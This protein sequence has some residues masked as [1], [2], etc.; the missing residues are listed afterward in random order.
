MLN[1]WLQ[2]VPHSLR[3]FQVL[4]ARWVPSP[5]R[6]LPR[7]KQRFAMWLREPRV[8]E[9]YLDL[10]GNSLLNETLRLSSSRPSVKRSWRRAV[11][12]A[13]AC[14]KVRYHGRWI[15]LKHISSVDIEQARRRQAGSGSVVVHAPR[16]P[17]AIPDRHQLRY[18]SVNVGGLPEHKYD[19]LL[20]YCQDNSVDV[21]A[22]Q[23][24]R[25]KHSMCWTSGSYR[26]IQSGEG[27]SVGKNSYAGVLVAISGKHLLS[28][29]EV[30]AGRLLLIRLSP[31][32]SSSTASSQQPP[33][34][35]VVFYNKVLSSQG[36][37]GD[38]A[39]ASLEVRS[40]LWTKLDTLLRSLPR[41]QG[42]LILGDLNCHVDKHSPYVASGDPSGATSIDE[43]D[44]I[45]LLERH[46][47][48]V[49][50]TGCKNKAVTFRKTLEDNPSSGT[51]PDYVILR[52][53][54]RR[55]ASRVTTHWHLPFSTP[56]IAGWHATLRG[57]LDLRWTCWRKGSP[58]AVQQR[59]HQPSIREAL[60]PEHPRQDAFLENLES[61]LSGL[62]WANADCA[63][64]LL[65]LND[66]VLKSGLEIFGAPSS[67]RRPPPWATPSSMRLSM[68]KW[69][70]FKALRALRSP[71]SL[72]DFF[73]CWK[74]ASKSMLQDRLYKQHCR[75][76]RQDWVR[77]ICEQASEAAKRR[78]HDFFRYVHMLAPKRRREAPGITRKLRGTCNM[79]EE[80]DRFLTHFKELFQS[81]APS[82]VQIP[83][84]WNWLPTSPTCED[85]EPYLSKMPL[86]KA[87]PVGHPL[88]SIWRLAFRSSSV[89]SWVNHILSEIPKSGVPSQFRNGSLRLLFK[90]GKKGDEVS[91]YRPLVL[92]CPLGKSILKWIGHRVFLHVRHL[93][94]RHPQFAYLP[95]RSAEMAIHRVSSFL[96]WRKS[97][98]GYAII[99]AE[100]RK[101]GWKQPDCSGCLLVSLDLTNAFDLVDREQLF[102][103]LSS[104][105]IPQDLVNVIRG[106]HFHSEYSLELGDKCY[107]IVTGRG[108]RQGCTLAPLLWLIY[109]YSTIEELRASVPYVDW[110]SLIT[111]YAD[112]LILCIPI[113]SALGMEEALVITQLFLQ[114]LSKKGLKINMLKTQFFLKLVG[115][116]AQ[117][118]FR[119]H[120]T[121]C[122]GKLSL[123]LGESVVPLAKTIDYLGVQLGWANSAD[124]TLG[125][126]LKKG[127][128]AFAS[129]RAWWKRSALHPR[130]QVDLY[131]ST[132][133]PVITYGL[134]S[135]G[136]TRKGRSRL[137]T[138]IFKQLRRI[139]RL[140]SH[141]THV[142]NATIIQRYDIIHPVL[143]VQL[144]CCRLW[145]QMLSTLSEQVCEA[146]HLS[147]YLDIHAKNTTPW[148]ESVVAGLRYDHQACTSPL[149]AEIIGNQ[150]ASKSAD[151]FR[152]VHHRGILP[153]A[154]ERM[155]KPSMHHFAS[156]VPSEYV[157]AE[158][159]RRFPT[160]NQLRSHQF[161]S[162]CLW[163][164]EEYTFVPQH[165]CGQ[166]LP[167]CRWC[168]RNF[169][170]WGALQTHISRGH[171]EALH[172]RPSP[173][174]PDPNKPRLY[175][176]DLDLSRFCVICARWFPLS[177]SL[178]KHLK[179]AH[180]LDYA[181]ATVEYKK[182]NFSGFKFK[183]AC[184]YCSTPQGS[185]NL[186]PHIKHHCV[187]L[188]QRFIAQCPDPLLQKTLGSEQVSPVHHGEESRGIDCSQLV[189][190][191]RKRTI[192]SLGSSTGTKA[193]TST[194]SRA[195]RLN[196][197]ILS[198]NSTYNFRCKHG[199]RGEEG[200]GQEQEQRQGEEQGTRQRS[201]SWPQRGRRQQF[202]SG[203]LSASSCQAS[204]LTSG[205]T[206]MYVTIDRSH[207]PLRSLSGE[208]H[209]TKHDGMLESMENDLCREPREDKRTPSG[210]ALEVHS[211]LPVH[212]RFRARKGDRA[213]HPRQVP[214]QGR[215]L[216]DHLGGE[217]GEGHPEAC[218]PHN[219][220]RGTECDS[221][222]DEHPLPL[223]CHREAQDSQANGSPVSRSHSTCSVEHEFHDSSRDAIVR[224]D[225]STHGTLPMAF[226]RCS[227][228]GGKG[229]TYATSRDCEIISVST[230]WVSSSLP[231][232]NVQ[233]SSSSSS[234]E[235]LLP[236]VNDG[237]LCYIN[238]TVNMICWAC[239]ACP[240]FLSSLPPTWRHALAPLLENA[241]SDRSGHRPVHIPSLPTWRPLLTGWRLGAQEDVS[242]FLL[243]VLEQSPVSAFAGT[244][245]LINAA[246]QHPET[247]PFVLLNVPVPKE[248][249]Q[250]DSSS[251]YSLS[252]IMDLWSRSGDSSRDRDCM[253]LHPPMLLL[254][255]LLRYSFEGHAQKCFSK[256]SVPEHVAIPS[257]IAGEI[258]STSYRCIA[259]ILHHGVDPTCGHYT[260]VAHSSAGHWHLDD[261]RLPQALT[262][263]AAEALASSDMYILCLER[264]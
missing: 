81:P 218:R 205:T 201:F 232:R 4:T 243:H 229:E 240:A 135:V 121:Y 112:D 157:C 198:S 225:A 237:T 169:K 193:K 26:V 119:S 207:L 18:L 94:L 136:L 77:H 199:G 153:T 150:I 106:W 109:L 120:T 33:L 197:S 8:A 57:S 22:V 84:E 59:F 221:G 154:Y 178:S 173:P 151:W 210:G 227:D 204:T 87:V 137:E 155:P 215:L 186:L 34:N 17:H 51:R 15:R 233:V 108:V 28:Y 222:R 64:P 139:L 226:D 172:L 71:R 105:D 189:H 255:Q 100:W 202:D 194:I 88:G 114:F 206:P 177:R 239:L 168:G 176:L 43:A 196:C 60:R 21:V 149:T 192:F 148:W 245:V 118:I 31:P 35:I 140:P 92:Q 98:A 19:A 126:R 50:N 211:C 20:Q 190:P 69:R 200:H 167:I 49:H 175:H 74:V 236:L 54:M 6:S 220:P 36:Y 79:S 191:S 40:Q 97:Q 256:I 208:R 29:E 32:S 127:R 179:S 235:S 39:A 1:T 143:R 228:E 164:K 96:S 217:D 14:G 38:V 223:G 65:T 37:D 89:K 91:H 70:C 257:M 46:D 158:C 73:L 83:N 247:Q 86:F 195:H 53:S 209:C 58:A 113:D 160:Y 124:L 244:M 129:L 68:L 45:S 10:C 261:S 123:K 24:T 141:L 47:L 216:R 259:T 102:T 144:A 116:K 75:Q 85:L 30:V 234:A 170:W 241:N 25:R 80:H 42:I 253:L 184:P 145:R 254:V 99:P 132:V 161:G 146:G 67:K 27:D 44:M 224:A 134:G 263:S 48:R 13:L 252:T 163:Q 12:R 122:E 110:L 165:D 214:H 203:H 63:D 238:S 183:H 188:L 111:A 264:V 9:L 142:S 212:A 41:R 166:A 76:L 181:R 219:E 187:V 52:S 11:Q 55:Q 242:E 115:K 7:F 5:N 231:D 258:V 125:L 72:A 213:D 156:S 2:P 82:Q 185:N 152:E 159:D 251:T 104:L 90:P 249:A 61:K 138:E 246:A 62:S 182:A 103:Y 260:C 130:A 23:E 128:Y 248:Q 262:R 101:A 162:A 16:V 3:T 174:V 131:V 93:L 230:T 56:S 95:G 250:D 171:C 180:A 147:S 117:K 66:A 133:L 107:Q 78:H